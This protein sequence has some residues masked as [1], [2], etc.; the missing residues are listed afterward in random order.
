[1]LRLSVGKGK[2]K[3]NRLEKGF[4]PGSRN[5]SRREI[6]HIKYRRWLAVTIRHKYIVPTFIFFVPESAK[7]V[8]VLGAARSGF[9]EENS[10]RWLEGCLGNG[11]SLIARYCVQFLRISPNVSEDRSLVRI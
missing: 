11:T 8:Y 4:L 9:I 6:S 2:I 3:T 5:D 10:S 1:M 7:L